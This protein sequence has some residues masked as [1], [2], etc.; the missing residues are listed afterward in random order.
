MESDLISSPDSGAGGG[1]V[2]N[3][4]A[5]NYCYKPKCS[6]FQRVVHPAVSSWE[7]S[8]VLAQPA[9]P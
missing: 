3:T 6:N 4:L 8:R 9:I 5:A 1:N 7:A 2:P